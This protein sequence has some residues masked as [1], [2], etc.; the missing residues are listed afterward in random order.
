M[1][2]VIYFFKCEFEILF[3]QIAS[4]IASIFEI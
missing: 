2:E 3:T 4:T 1:V